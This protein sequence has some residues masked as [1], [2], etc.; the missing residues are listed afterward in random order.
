M[1]P[2]TTGWA[3]NNYTLKMHVSLGNSLFMQSNGIFRVKSIL[4]AFVVEPCWSMVNHAVVSGGPVNVW[5]LQQ[6]AYG[7]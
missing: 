4:E 5:E 7:W 6:V 2:N 1:S 3:L